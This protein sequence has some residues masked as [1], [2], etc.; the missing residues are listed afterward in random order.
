MTDKE[1]IIEMLQR[2]GIEF[3]ME[4]SGSKLNETVIIVCGGYVGFYSVFTFNA[5]GSLSNLEA[6]E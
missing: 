1:T 3:S 6:Y 2:A 5:E 4:R